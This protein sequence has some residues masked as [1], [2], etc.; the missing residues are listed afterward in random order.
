[1]L[2]RRGPAQA[3]FTSAEL[4]ELGRL[5]GVDLASTRPTSSSTRSRSEWLAEE[6]TFTARKNVELLREFA[7]RPPRADAARR[8][9][10]RFLRSPVAIRG[11]RRVEA[12]DVAPQRDRARR[13]RH[14]AARGRSTT[15]SRRSSA[16]SSCA[17]SATARCRCPTCRSTSATSCCP[18]ERGR[19]LDAR[20]ASRFPAS[21][22]SAGSSAARPGSSAR[23]SA[24]PRRRSRCLAED[25]RRRAAAPPSPRASD[26]R[27]ARRAQAGRRHGR[28]LARDR[29]A[30][31]RP[32]AR[33][34]SARGS[35]S[36][37]ATSCSQRLASGIFCRRGDM[38]RLRA[39]SLRS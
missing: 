1:M 16:G 24:T 5:D 35:S 3:A 4:R 15:T 8:I 13:R 18:N 30:G 36:R 38:P 2:G 33:R 22:R 10:L 9:E 39:W 17:R 11:D 12:V 19:V 23:T 7:A 26:R 6:G 21:T 25:L 14:A 31:A 37:R 20:T 29:R 34:A 27:A 32:R 28:R